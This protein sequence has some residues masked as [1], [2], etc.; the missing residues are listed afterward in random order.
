MKTWVHTTFIYIG[1]VREL[2]L[3]SVRFDY[4]IQRSGFIDFS[5]LSPLLMTLINNIIYQ[6]QNHKWRR[7]GGE[8][9]VSPD[10]EYG[11]WWGLMRARLLALFKYS[12]KADKSKRGCWAGVIRNPIPSKWSCDVWL[13][14]AWKK[15]QKHIEMGIFPLLSLCHP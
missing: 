4:L 15:G 13:T 5:N 2:N 11:E 8:K 12:G 14:C 9:G 10:S 7:F 6:H 3:N 1:G